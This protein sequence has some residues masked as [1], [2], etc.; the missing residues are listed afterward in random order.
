MIVLLI[1]ILLFLFI[2][3]KNLKLNEFKFNKSSKKTVIWIISLNNKYD[4]EILNKCPYLTNI[5]KNNF[6]KCDVIELSVVHI[7]KSNI[8]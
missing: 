4:I 1:A 3:Q 2:F 6:E 7:W 5:Y 8:I